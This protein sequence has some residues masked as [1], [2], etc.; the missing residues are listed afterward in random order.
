M[1]SFKSGDLVKFRHNQ[2]PFTVLA[3][4]EPGK[5]TISAGFGKTLFEVPP[6]LLEF[7]EAE[8]VALARAV[9]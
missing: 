8:V 5:L 1:H 9:A 6:H 3:E 2:V 4:P 7:A